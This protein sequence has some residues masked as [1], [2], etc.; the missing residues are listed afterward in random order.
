MPILHN[1]DSAMQLMIDTETGGTSAG[2]A[3]FSIGAVIF[4][5]FSDNPP[6]SEFYV[7]ISHASNMEI[8]LRFD[9]A[10]MDWWKK[11]GTPPNGETHILQAITDLH[12]W[13]KRSLPLTA[14]WANS[15]SFDISII[16]YVM[17]YYRMEWP[18]AFWLE[19][20]VR[21]MKAIAWP[22]NEY[23]LNNS[24][25]ALDD[26]KNQARLIQDA[27]YT[28]RL[29]THANSPTTEPSSNVWKLH[30]DPI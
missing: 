11:V 1:E 9:R 21:T 22:N 5:A 24:H 3:I 7:E 6:K 8:G 27:Y 29:S 12:T 19:R 26:A 10:T 2:C 23:K 20:D 15:P 28:L 13:I 4:D 17:R 18:L 25:N 30:P 14:Y 16:N